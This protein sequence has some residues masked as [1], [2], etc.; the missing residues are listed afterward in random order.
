M[1]PALVCGSAIAASSWILFDTEV[2]RICDPHVS[3]RSKEY[4][5]LDADTIGQPGHFVKSNGMAANQSGC[6]YAP[7]LTG[8]TQPA[9]LAFGSPSTPLGNRGMLL[10]LVF[11]FCCALRSKTEHSG[12]KYHAAARPERVEAMS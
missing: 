1:S 7:S 4:P 10:L 3:P 5:E 9:I 11:G 2:A 6:V 8:L 12:W